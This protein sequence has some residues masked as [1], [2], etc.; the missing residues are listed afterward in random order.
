MNKPDCIVVGGGVIGLSLAWVLGQQGVRVLVIDRQ[1]V[2]RGT[3]WAGV[4]IFPP[5]NMN[6]AR[7]PIDKLRAK[8]H[9]LHAE[10]AEKLQSTTG[11]DTGYRRCGG[12]YLALSRGEQAALIGQANYWQEYGIESHRLESDS[13]AEIEPALESIAQSPRLLSAWLLSDEALLRSPDHLLALR[14]ACQQQGVKFQESC[15]IQD[16]VATEGKIDRIV[17]SAGDFQADNYCLTAGAWTRLLLDQLGISSGI[18]PVRGQVLLY[19][20]PQQIFTRVVNEGN[21]YLVPRDDGHILVGSNEEEVGFQLGNSKTVVDLLRNWA[22]GVLPALKDQPIIRTWSGLR[23][24]SF[25]SFP[26]I[27]KLPG[28]ANGFIASGHY[29]SGLHLSCATATELA[30][31]VLE[32][33]T[34]LDLA[35]FSPGRG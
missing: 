29:R 4:G 21:R 24:A 16:L 22:E 35:P 18:Y 28:L 8:S 33:P 2:G 30:N 14:M 11:I 32:K 3:S 31:L 7:D 27:G 20:L 23:P 5:A 13:L 9:V 1:E 26:Y 19:K 25:D 34:Q 6:T 17:S 12:I 15:E 10:W